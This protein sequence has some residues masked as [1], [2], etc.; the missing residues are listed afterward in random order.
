[1]RTISASYLESMCHPNLAICNL[2][3][4]PIIRA[5]TRE[6]PKNVPFIV[7][8]KL[9]KRF[10]EQWDGPTVTLLEDVERILSVYMRGLV[11]TFFTQHSYG[12]LHNAV[13]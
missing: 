1:M 13:G 2:I 12:G 4:Q 5:V 3:N 9:I 6:L 8:R 10:V 11:D 7:K